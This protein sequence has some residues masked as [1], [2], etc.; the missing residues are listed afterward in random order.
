MFLCACLLRSVA[1]VSVILL[2]FTLLSAAELASLPGFALFETLVQQ[3]EEFHVAY[4]TPWRFVHESWRYFSGKA[5]DTEVWTEQLEHIYK[6]IDVLFQSESLEIFRPFSKFL[7][8]SCAF[9][10][11]KLV[12]FD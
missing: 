6:E 12:K 11:L 2:I 8:H 5:L 3:S 10:D 1:G 4:Q 7:F 9:D